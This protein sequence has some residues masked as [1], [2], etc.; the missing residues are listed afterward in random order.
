[1]KPE[2][3]IGIAILSVLYWIGGILAILVG[4]AVLSVG[5]LAPDAAVFLLLA[6][7][8]L[9]NIALGVLGCAVG[10]GLWRLDTWAWWTVLIL[11]IL[12]ALGGLVQLAVP[13]YPEAP[14]LPVP[15][16]LINA[17]V[18]VY[19]LTPGV[20]KAFGIAAPHPAP[21]R[22]RPLAA[23]RCVNPACGAEISPGWRYCPRCLTP[24]SD[25][26]VLPPVRHCTNTACRRPIQPGW[27]YCPYCLTSMAAA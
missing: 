2:R 19:L 18:L 3:P 26:A 21:H 27:K 9:L 20:Q 15:G 14:W 16:L 23:F 17:V 11:T 1:M 4:L 8:A 12:S 22:Y 7:L 25:R 10:R 13:P 6:G 5:A 24:V